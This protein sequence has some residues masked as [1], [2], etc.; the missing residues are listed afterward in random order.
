MNTISTGRQ[1]ELKELL[2]SKRYR[3]RIDALELLEIL[4]L[5]NDVP[6][7]FRFE[8][9]WLLV[10]PFHLRKRHERQQVARFLDIWFRSEPCPSLCSRLKT[11][12]LEE[13]DDKVRGSLQVAIY[14]TMPLSELTGSIARPAKGD[15]LQGNGLLVLLDAIANRVK[16][17]Q[18]PASSLRALVGALRQG[19][20]HRASHIARPYLWKL[21]QVL[22]RVGAPVVAEAAGS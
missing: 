7:T 10:D 9:G 19:R 3:D 18:I 2:A 8:V 21:E 15:R 20:A 13:V 5:T 12:S 16:R 17:H 11:I 6:G 1:T 4:P 14:N 22:E